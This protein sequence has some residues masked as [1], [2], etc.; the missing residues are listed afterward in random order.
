MKWFI[1]SFVVLA[2]VSGCTLTG[3]RSGSGQDTGPRATVQNS[4]PDHYGDPTF[5][6]ETV[7]SEPVAG[8]GRDVPR[9]AVVSREAAAPELENRADLVAGLD[10]YEQARYRDARQRLTRALDSNLTAENEAIAL[11]KLRSINE[12]I[13]LSTGQDGDLR[14][15]KVEQGDFPARIAKNMGTTWEL[16]VRLNGL[17]DRD[18]RTLQIGRELKVPKGT[19]E[20]R[21]RKSKYVMDLLL[22]GNFIQRYEVGLGVGGSTPLGEY[23]IRNRIPE[24]ADGAYPF[25]HQQHRLGTRWMGIHSEDGYKGYGIHGCRPEQER[26]IPGECSQGCIRM[27]NAQVEEVFDIVPVGTRVRV[28]QK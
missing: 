3:V 1:A 17:T 11:A 14:T 6:R 16:I 7:D 24:P 5:H 4:E 8:Y 28:T 25:G 2:L 9:D 21:V 19:F 20:L 23:A 27:T 15:Y 22:D 13:F 18:I 26:E 12:R 10:L